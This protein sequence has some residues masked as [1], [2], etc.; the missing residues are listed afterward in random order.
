MRTMADRGKSI[1]RLEEDK[2]SPGGACEREKK[3]GKGAG[4]KCACTR[5]QGN[6]EFISGFL[7]CNDK[8]FRVLIIGV[9]K[10]PGAIGWPR[11]LT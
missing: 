11:I 8:G 3:G 4:G 10:P 5:E 6:S 2:R 9:S 1:W 7:F